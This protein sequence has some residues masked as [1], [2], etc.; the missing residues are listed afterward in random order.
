MRSIKKLILDLGS[1]FAQGTL[2]ESLSVAGAS[3]VPIAFSPFVSIPVLFTAYALYYYGK[4]KLSAD[5][6]K[7]QLDELMKR[8]LN[9]HASRLTQLRETQI[10]ELEKILNCYLTAKATHEELS[11]LKDFVIE[12][13]TNQQ[14]TLDL[15]VKET[16][17]SETE[18]CLL[19]NNSKEILSGIEQIDKN[20][21]ALSACVSDIQTSL[22]ELSTKNDK[23][24]KFLTENCFSDTQFTLANFSSNTSFPKVKT[25]FSASRQDK[26]LDNAIDFIIQMIEK[27]NYEEAFHKTTEIFSDVKYQGS[28][29]LIAWKHALW[30][31]IYY[32]Q[33]DGEKG[34]EEAEKSEKSFNKAALNSIPTFLAVIYARRHISSDNLDT[35]KVILERSISENYSSEAKALL[36]SISKTSVAEDKETL[37]ESEL[38]K[39]TINVVLARKSLN[40]GNIEDA[41]LFARKAY[42]SAKGNHI[43]PP[44]DVYA[45]SLFRKKFPAGMVTAGFMRSYISER[46]WPDAIQIIDLYKEC[47]NFLSE[48][49]SDKARSFFL[50]NIALVYFVC[51]KEAEAAH[52]AQKFFDQ[53]EIIE[54]AIELCAIILLKS[55]DVKQCLC[56]LEKFEKSLPDDAL[57]LYGTLLM[58]FDSGISK[59]INILEQVID[60][61]CIANSLSTFCAAMRLGAH[62]IENGE[63]EKIAS[64]SERL[65]N[66]NDYLSYYALAA[67]Q[68]EKRSSDECKK[69]LLDL[70]PYIP[71]GLHERGK[72]VAVLTPL[73][74]KVDLFSELIQLMDCYVP[75][76]EI[77]E[78]GKTYFN[79]AL[80]A[81]D[82]ARIKKFGQALRSAGIWD[83]EFLIAELNFT[84]S[85]SKFEAEQLANECLKLVTDLPNKQLLQTFRDMVAIETG[86]FHAYSHK[87]TDYPSIE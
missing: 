40:E 38:E 68:N 24:D 72:I 65:Q 53:N 7:T 1:S 27:G 18:I 60:K 67:K 23:I 29:E 17:F 77:T 35:A 26:S 45:D 61:S 28:H 5:D 10:T 55:K 8:I 85:Y 31:C 52:Y 86:N 54:N 42:D 39:A 62:W 82:Q 43:V 79:L 81:K 83:Q 34:N 58:D 50:Y 12:T 6:Q 36:L 73:F 16:Q 71:T 46:E 14:K 3:L 33:Y 84:I 30:A 44:A 15:I 22:Q 51:G 25:I 32:Y 41:I 19:L 70:I 78:T 76:D 59:G 80:K 11:E 2:I 21:T 47:L 66:K 49:T 20:I 64:L 9:E 75:T 69:N 63:N 48:R 4:E 56:N 37:T 13:I 74:C 57:C 87:L